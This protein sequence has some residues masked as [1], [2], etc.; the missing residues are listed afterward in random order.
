[1][2]WPGAAG[3]QQPWQSGSG[4]VVQSQQAPLS[5]RN[6]LSGGYGSRSQPLMAPATTLTNSVS[7]EQS[8]QNYVTSSVTMKDPINSVA[9][10]P[11]VA[12]SPREQ[13]WE[14]RVQELTELVRSKDQ[15]IRE[16]QDQNFQLRKEVQQTRAAAAVRAP[17]QPGMNNG[18]PATFGRPNKAGKVAKPRIPYV[19]VSPADPVDL[20][21]EEWYN[22]TDS[23]IPF[24][25][26][27]QRFYKFGET[28]VELDIINHKL[29][30]RTE[31]GWNRGKFSSIER[32]LTVYENHERRRL[33]T[34]YLEDHFMD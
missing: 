10:L 6:Q 7:P 30:A 25:R 17:V 9:V 26:I 14:R 24:K 1:M 22:A 18:L 27:N 5:P 31:D 28:F 33:A 11:S 34:R 16:L 2:Q 15:R 20:R 13:M 3:N 8:G 12:F 4:M 29:M 21:L 23:S 32:F 19:A